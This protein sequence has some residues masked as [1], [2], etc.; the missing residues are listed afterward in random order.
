MR[1]FCFIETVKSPRSPFAIPLYF[2]FLKAAEPLRPLFCR[3]LFPNTTLS[4]FNLGLKEQ[5]HTK[6]QK[7]KN[8]LPKTKEIN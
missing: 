3:P 7:E 2:F 5:K 6:K 1:Q 4:R 8:E